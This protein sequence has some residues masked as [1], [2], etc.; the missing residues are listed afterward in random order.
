MINRTTI[1]LLLS[2]IIFLNSC[3][4]IT[5]EQVPL[6]SISS[7]YNNQQINGND[8]VFITGSISD[9]N[10]VKSVSISLRNSND[11]PV[12]PTISYTPNEKDFSFNTPYFFDDLHMP[13]GQYYFSIQASDGNNTTSKYINIS[14][15]EI[16]KTRTGVFFYDNSGNSTSI[17]QLNANSANLFKT[18]NSDFLGGAANSYGQQLISVGQYNAKIMAY[19]ISTGSL[20]WNTAYPNSSVPYYTNIF[21]HDKELYVGIRNG[22]IRAYNSNGSPTYFSNVQTNYYP[23]NGLVHDNVFISEEKAI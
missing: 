22:E 13:S 12:L 2:F 15:G 5:D 3:E 17:Y 20:V 4:K 18:V 8:T 14:Y 7:P 11:I 23:E 6:I 10:V 9:N 19:D 16:P 21:F 1:L